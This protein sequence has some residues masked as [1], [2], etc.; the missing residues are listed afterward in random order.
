M[1]RTQ[2]LAGELGNIVVDVPPSGRYRARASMRHDSSAVHRLSA[3]DDTEERARA[4]VSRQ[5]MA[6][7]T[8]GTGALAPSSTIADAVELWL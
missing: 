5:A 6:L 1:V 4:D 8:G 3:V 2:I 7:T